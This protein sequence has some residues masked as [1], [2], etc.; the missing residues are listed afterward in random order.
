MSHALQYARHWPRF[1][2]FSTGSGWP[3]TG[4]LH[5]KQGTGWPGAIIGNNLFMLQ[6]L[7]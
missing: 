5:M 7:N 6:A 4:W 3:A 1:G 2:G